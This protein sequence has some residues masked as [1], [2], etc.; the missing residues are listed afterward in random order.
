[1][2]YVDVLERMPANSLDVVFETLETAIGHHDEFHPLASRLAMYW[3]RAGGD[4]FTFIEAIENSELGRTYPKKRLGYHASTA[5]RKAERDFEPV[6]YDG[7]G[8]VAEQLANVAVA[9]EDSDLPPKVK[10]TAKALVAV[11]VERGVYTVDVS[12]REL[13]E[14]SGNG[15]KTCIR[16]LKLLQGVDPN[17]RRK[18]KFQPMPVP[19]I[20]SSSPGALGEST[21]Y[22]LDLRWGEGV[23]VDSSNMGNC[24]T[25]KSPYSELS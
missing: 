25:H 23:E 18:G 11:A 22:K 9:V 21:N 14:R 7:G 13:A 6:Y 20:V 19:L 2:N 17:P 5:F 12:A 15:F 16:H 8:S 4:E 24:D 1:M 3:L 10:A